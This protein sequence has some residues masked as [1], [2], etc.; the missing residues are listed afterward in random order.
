MMSQNLMMMMRYVGG[1]L[2]AINCRLFTSTA[3]HSTTS[4]SIAVHSFCW[5]A[6][7]M[8][9]LTPGAHDQP[10]TLQVLSLRRLSVVF[11]RLDSGAG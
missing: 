11:N 10:S 6:V 8:S 1:N 7:T 2:Y 3:G 5:I 4:M 9:L